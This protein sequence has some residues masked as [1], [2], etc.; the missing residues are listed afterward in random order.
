MSRQSATRGPTAVTWAPQGGLLRRTLE[1][2]ARMLGV[3][4]VP[5]PLPSAPPTLAAPPAANAVAARVPPGFR[6]AW[7]DQLWGDGMALP[8]GA[9]EVLRLAALLP[10][11]AE[12]TLLLAG[13]G[14]RM[15][16]GIIA[17][18]RGG[19]VAA[20]EPGAASAQPPAPRGRVTTEAF[21]VAAPAFQ[22]RYHHHALLLEPLRGGGSPDALLRATAAGLK[23]GG[24]VVLIDLVAQGLPAG[25][26]EAR[27]LAAEGRSKAPPAEAA[28]PGALRRAGFQIHVVEDAGR[29]HRDA[30]LAG[31][32]ALILALRRQAARPAA[33]E[34][35]DLVA[36]AEA[37]LLRVRLLEEGR[38][39]LLRWHAS[40]AP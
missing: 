27:W 9:N 22:A 1:T 14:A 32:Q 29:R 31:W 34:A 21:D 16:G 8:G 10:L 12:I 23:P 40:M 7:S 24:Q 3:G 26:A 39:R 36:E 30:V 2:G 18:A 33:A 35:A 4:G 15:A 20:L 17:K 28:I 6:R 11:S 38:L 13:N 37:W 25:T 19:F 5:T